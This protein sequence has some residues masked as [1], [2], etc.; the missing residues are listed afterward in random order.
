MIYDIDHNDST[1][2]RTRD[3]TTINWCRVFDVAI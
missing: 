1:E 3:T 2:S